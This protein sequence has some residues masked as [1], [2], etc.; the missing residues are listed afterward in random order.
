M[1]KTELVVQVVV[2]DEEQRDA[3]LKAIRAKTQR[4]KVDVTWT[5]G[6]EF[7]VEGDDHSAVVSIA[8][9][10]GR[11]AREAERRRI[12]ALIEFV[13]KELE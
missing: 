3:V 11:A 7:H 2:R 1:A 8:A 5:N 13:N 9:A 4:L 6:G 10:L 12:Q